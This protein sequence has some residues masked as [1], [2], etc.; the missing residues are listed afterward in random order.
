[1]DYI[2]LENFTKTKVD[3]M[4]LVQAAL[5]ETSAI[6]D[7]KL[8]PLIEGAE[9]GGY[10]EMAELFEMFCYGKNNVTPNYEMA[11]RYCSR[12]QEENLQSD[13]PEVISEGLNAIAYM[14]NTFGNIE[15]AKEAFLTAFKYM[16]SKLEP[17]NWDKQ[18]IQL[19]SYNIDGY[20]GGLFAH[21]V[22]EE[23]E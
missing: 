1:M 2:Y 18:I 8:F 23:M 20:Q 14:E 21:E 22:E 9:K 4:E 5:Q 11:Y 13:N 19:V 12:L 15:A 17:E 3:N 16:V 10:A 7:V 6:V